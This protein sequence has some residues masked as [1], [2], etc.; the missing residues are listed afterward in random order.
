MN[1]IQLFSVSPAIPAQ[2]AFLEKLSRNM[3]WSW[4]HDAI[5]LFRRIDPKAWKESG[6]NPI[7]FLSRVPQKTLEAL[8]EDDGF[9]SHQ[10]QVMERFDLEVVKHKNGSPRR[11]Q[12]DC[13]AYFSLEYGIHESV[14]FYAGGL[15]C[16]AGDFLK[17]AS[18]MDLPLVAVG[19]LYL[20]GY[21]QQCLNNDG[22]QQETYL[23]NDLHQLPISEVFDAQNKKIRVKLPLPEGALLAA[24]WR[25]DVGRIPLYLLDTNIPENPPD[26]RRITLRLYEAD[27]LLRIRQELLLGIGGFRALI[28]AGFNP[29]VCHMNEGHAAFLGLERVSHAMK[30]L[31]LDRKT[32]MEIVPRTGVFTTHT[33]VP[34]GNE[35][36]SV[37]L[38][39]QHLK[40]LEKELGI[41]AD[42][43]VSWGQS[44]V[45]HDNHHELSMTVLGLR[46]ADHSNG[47]SRLHGRVAR[48]MWAH[49]WP[50]RPADEIPICHITN[51]VHISSWLSSD[52]ILLFDKYLGPEWRDN[53]AENG[54]LSRVLNIP[55]DELW[56][57]HQL[58]RARMIRRARE[59][60][61]QQLTNRNAPRAD[62][63]KIKSIFHYD[64]LTL[65]FA[66]RFA[67]Y[68]RAALLL[69]DQARFEALLSDK[70]HPIQVVFAGKSHPADNIGK[71]IIRQIV[72]FSRKPSIRHRIMFVENYDI[73]TAR[74]F[75]QGADVWLNTPRRPQE[76]SG[77]SGMKAA[78]NG[79]LHLS[80]LDGWWDEGYDESRGWS[81]GNG[82]EYDNQEYNDMIEAQ[83][84]YNLLEDEIVPC[85][86]ERPDGDVPC[87]WT[88]K[89]KASIS[90]ALADFTSHRMLTQYDDMFYKK[91]R[92]AYDELTPNK[93]EKA[94]KLV[95]QHDRLDALW[96]EVKIASPEADKDVSLLHVGDKFNVRVRVHLGQLTP[97]E[98]NV[99]VYYGQ[100]SSDN[101]ITRSFSEPMSLAESR[102]DGWHVYRH[103][104]V[105]RTSGRCGFTARVT[106]R[107]D[108]WRSVMPGFITWPSV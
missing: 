89:M 63:A 53:P 49:L 80:V 41:E 42:T 69:Q 19:L 20:Q 9:L 14:R 32:A 26:M 82:E 21:F 74:Y 81:I 78:V 28:A 79:C 98:A 16:L 40:P 60:G 65:V 31:S 93:A 25:L 10:E 43:A 47:V 90:M 13:I 77:T 1:G 84:L 100:V 86:Y 103:E 102:S 62:V 55:D 27:R 83:A 76:A 35:T 57:A 45:N 39:K 88:Q 15:G 54:V 70:E 11:P 104:I 38:V 99:E 37:D 24:V 106:P 97:E 91:A 75:A 85:F 56:H 64:V 105:C 6:H 44:P 87:E 29:S 52:M 58:G 66:R 96:Q 2:L 5:E 59:L 107:G 94:R 92:R 48:R 61:E 108:E 72:H 67:S 73:L 68:K 71:D 95:A 7:D 50:E 18:D 34:A 30:T 8:A 33:P 23:E 3:W 22:W 36:F 51:G 12:S 4:N 101:K 17:E 46:M